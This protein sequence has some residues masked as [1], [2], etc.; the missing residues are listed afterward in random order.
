MGVEDFRPAVFGACVA[1]RGGNDGEQVAGDAP[2]G[3]CRPDPGHDEDNQEF[4]SG[5]RP[6][7]KP[8]AEQRVE[9]DEQEEGEDHPQG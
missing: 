1:V 2:G 4:I 9:E 3:N 7:R 5:Q 8:A 6:T